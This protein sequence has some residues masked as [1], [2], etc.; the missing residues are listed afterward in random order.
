MNGVSVPPPVLVGAGGAL[1]AVLR[2][3]VGAVVDADGY[4]ASTLLVNSL[5]TFA[6]AALTLAGASVD[7]AL[8]FGTGA[9]GA[10]TTFSS[11]SVD[12]VRLVEDERLR[13][14]AFH[15]AGNLAGAALAVAFAWLLVA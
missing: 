15:A 4:P 1:G 10:F 6:L 7:A 13:A 3:R 14:A 2:W 8:L 12:V 5:G 11:F 9:C